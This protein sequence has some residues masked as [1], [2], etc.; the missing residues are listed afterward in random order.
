MPKIKKLGKDKEDLNSSTYIQSW[1][2]FHNALLFLLTLGSKYVWYRWTNRGQSVLGFLESC[3][4]QQWAVEKW[5]I[6]CELLSCPLKEEPSCL[7]SKI[8]L[9][10]WGPYHTSSQWILKIPNK[11]SEGRALSLLSQSPLPTPVRY[12]TIVPWRPQSFGGEI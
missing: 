1:C 11:V 10:C 2:S 12:P 5:F 6:L 8:N 7:N 9:S 4:S 3:Q